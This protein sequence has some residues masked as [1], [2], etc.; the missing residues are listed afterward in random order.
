[1]PHTHALSR[2]RLAA[3]SA[4]LLLAASLVGAPSA[5]ATAAHAGAP[6]ADPPAPHVALDDW[7][8]PVSPAEVTAG[9][10]APAHEYGPGHRGIDLRAA[11][12]T[13]IAS[14][15]AGVVA[16][17][18]SVAGRPLVTIDHGA[19]LVTT[20][21]PVRALVPVGAAVTAAQTVGTVDAGGHTPPGSAHFGVREHGEYINPMLLFG[22]VPR[23][24]LLP[25]C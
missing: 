24:V 13:E 6:A 21:E 19:G 25:C 8:W 16:F 15:A 11:L 17:A 1:M 12:G 20:L 3:A 18:G 7:V 5:A 9:F 22:E 4:A 2:G 10:A 14:P 23:A